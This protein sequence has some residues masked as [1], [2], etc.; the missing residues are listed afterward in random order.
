MGISTSL[1]R[2]SALAIAVVA[3]LAFS[4]IATASASATEWVQ[5]NTTMK[6]SNS[7]ITLKKGESSATCSASGTGTTTN[8]GGF[9]NGSVTNGGFVVKASCLG[10]TKVEFCA[11]IMA[12]K[13]IGAGV[14]AVKMWNWWG[15]LPPYTSP[16]GAYAQG[17]AQ[18]TFTNGS[19]GTAS[20]LSFSNATLGATEPGGVPIT[21]SGTFNV[22]TGSGGLLTIKG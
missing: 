21:I 14:Y 1:Q 18:A 9:A 4:A 5:G 2:R 13:S 17:S 22:T 3:A 12:E 10:G 8:S 16:F 15:G 20:T 19:G 6:W 7:T 11:C